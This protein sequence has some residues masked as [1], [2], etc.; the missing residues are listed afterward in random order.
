MNI[1]E[2]N[3]KAARGT[4]VP[5]SSINDPHIRKIINY[6]HKNANVPVKQ[7]EDQIQEEVDRLSRQ[8]Q[9]SPLL[10]NTMLANA[11]ERALF[12]M[13]KPKELVDPNEI[14]ARVMSGKELPVRVQ[15]PATSPKF[16][17][18][19]FSALV[20]RVKIENQSLF[21]LR[22]FHDKKPIVSPRIILIPSDD[23]ETQKKFG[24]IDTA[25][26]T[27]NGEFIFNV[28]FMQQCLDYAHIAGL[29]SKFK[30]YKSNG[31]QFPDEYAMLE[32]LILHEFYHYTHA[33]FHYHKVLK[34]DEGKKAKG[35]IINW[36]GDF[37]T[38]YDLLKAGH[39]PIPVGLYNEEVNYD[40]QK[41]YAEMYNLVK[42]EL[43]K[44]KEAEPPPKVG[45][46]IYS[47]KSGGYHVVTAVSADGKKVKARPATPDEIQDYRKPKIAKKLPMNPKP[48]A[49]KTTP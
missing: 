27:P 31:G 28:H 30:K 38:N 18:V 48:A 8:A 37:R 40:R 33:D 2:S 44:L 16:N 6:I 36:V 1:V 14:L 17:S 23:P 9:K 34:D 15:S 49:G 29:K 32:F 21:P 42:N 43:K 4:L 26:A 20:R 22:N 10:F 24:S 13:F 45:D 5:K 19:D 3:V 11:V 25:A 39:V 47:K 7:I 41:E 46:V 35:K 12:N